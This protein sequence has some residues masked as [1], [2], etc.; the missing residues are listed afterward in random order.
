VATDGQRVAEPLLTTAQAA[1]HLDIPRSTIGAWAG[2]GLVASVPSEGR[3]R[4]TL[5]L[6]AV[7][8]AQV[9]YG[10]RRWGLHGGEIRRAVHGLRAEFGPYALLTQRLASD[11]SALLR[12]LGGGPVPRWERVVDGQAMLPTVVDDHLR[13]FEW[14]PDG[15]PQRLTLRSYARHGADVVLDPRFGY[16]Q[17]VFAATKTRVVDVLGQLA[18]GERPDDVAGDY[19][20]TGVEVAAAAAI[21]GLAVGSATGTESAV[22]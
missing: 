9:L 10:L 8:E 18:A 13:L 1:M 19:G 5:P 2:A 7:A 17:P 16:G 3:F 4:P 20:L 12:E 21:A 6:V 22:A 14:D 11:G 15:Y